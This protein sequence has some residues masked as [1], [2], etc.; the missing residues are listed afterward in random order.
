MI[1]GTE[2][3]SALAAI[4]L[5]DL[6][7]AGDNALVIALAAR[8]LPK[9]LQRRAIAWGT[10]GAV[11]VRSGLTVAVLWVL[12]IPGL[13]LAGGALLVWIAWRLLAGDEASRQHELA[14]AMTFWSAM[15]TIVIADAVMGLDNVLAV[16][17]AAVAAQNGAGAAHGSVLLVVLG[18]LISIPI[19]VWGSTLILR[20]IERFPVLLYAGG[21]VLAWT[22]VKMMTGEPLVNDALA[23]RPLV[24]ALLYAA[25]VGGVPAAAWLRNRRLEPR[26]ALK[27]T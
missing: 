3:W 21:G 24:T 17:G 16:G 22:A 9:T 6:V 5:I 1:P 27:E 25:I 7:L 14:P 20:W 26:K 12:Q 15:R 11:V 2:F 4:V 13:M 18:L 10:V 23:G 19:M 8:K